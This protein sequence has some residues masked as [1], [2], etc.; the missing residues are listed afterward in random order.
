MGF[1]PER[2]DDDDALMNYA[3]VTLFFIVLTK[4]MYETN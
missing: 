1:T 2:L 4:V 3:S